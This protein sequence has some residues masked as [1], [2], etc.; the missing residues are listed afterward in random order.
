MARSRSRKTGFIVSLFAGSALLIATWGTP[1]QADGGGA[2]GFKVV[3][4][5]YAQEIN[6]AA[7]MRR[8]G[9]PD[10]PDPNSKGVFSS[11]SID[12]KSPQ[13]QN[14]E[15][16]CQDLLPKANPPTAAEQAKLLE[17]GVALATCMRSHGVL[18]FSDPTV[19]KG[20]GIVFSLGG[21]DPTSPQFQRA[22]KACQKLSPL[23]GGGPLAP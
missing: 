20:G 4:A 10:F 16:A 22:V 2:L 23:P 9:E 7:C 19:P 3:G 6:F 15:N 11:S 18:N 12:T 13:Y 21:A 8:H 1:A 5:S 14:A 17:K